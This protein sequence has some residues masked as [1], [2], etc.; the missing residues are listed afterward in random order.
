MNF[1][2]HDGFETRSDGINEAV[3]GSPYASQLKVFEDLG[4][5]VLKNAQ[6]GLGHVLIKS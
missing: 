1:R 3:A 6:E 5:G 4:R 2:S